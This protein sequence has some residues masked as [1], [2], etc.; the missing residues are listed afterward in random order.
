MHS[1]VYH[2]GSG[3]SMIFHPVTDGMNWWW[4]TSNGH[5]R[6]KMAKLLGICIFI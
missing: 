2:M 5:W 1:P 4:R 6:R 3:G